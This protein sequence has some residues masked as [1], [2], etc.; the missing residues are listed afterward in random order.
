VSVRF[1][2][3]L[4]LAP[5]V[6]GACGGGSS[7]PKEAPRL[8]QKQFVAAANRVCIDSDRRIFHI[9]ALS[10]D[11]SGWA[12]TAAAAKQAIVDMHAVHPP[13]AAQRGFDT[14]MRDAVEV[15]RQIQL[16]HDAL[17]AHKFGKARTAQFAATDADSR[18]KHQAKK[19]GLTFCEQL[20]TNWPA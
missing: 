8:T 15:R 4:L 10:T 3:L 9:G 18:I 17:A 1:A 5:L 6:A 14:M 13:L 11:P 16:V 2:L 12:K 7:K 19:L 20:L